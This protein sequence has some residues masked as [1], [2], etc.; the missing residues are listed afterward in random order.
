ML[1]RNDSQVNYS[2]DLIP[3]SSSTVY[4]IFL[5]YS[6]SVTLVFVI[7]SLMRGNREKELFQTNLPVYFTF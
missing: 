1:S 3:L 2:P 4:L 5:H 6:I 7:D